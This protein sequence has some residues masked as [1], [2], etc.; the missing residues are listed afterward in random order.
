MEVLILALVVTI[1]TGA[2]YFEGNVTRP[3]W[4][5]PDQ[6]ADGESHAIYGTGH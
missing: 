3:V 2:H 1:P 4:L 5:W 6:L